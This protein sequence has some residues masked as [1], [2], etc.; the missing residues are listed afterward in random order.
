ME[1]ATIIAVLAFGVAMIAL[2]LVSDVIKKVEGQNEKFVKA[3]ISVLRE[4]MR[5]MDKN[6]H[7]VA[8]AVA[9]TATQVEGLDGRLNDHTKLLDGYKSRFAELSQQLQDLDNSIPQRFRARVAAKEEK[10]KAKPS[11]Q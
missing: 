2:W 10:P 4:E 1:F 5:E 8:R 11:I 9:V 7:K 6:V 3:H